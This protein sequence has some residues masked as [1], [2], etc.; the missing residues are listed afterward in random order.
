M[1]LPS[2]RM[3][4]PTGGLLCCAS[5]MAFVQ[6]TFR[7]LLYCWGNVLGVQPG[8]IEPRSLCVISGKGNQRPSKHTPPG[9]RAFWASSHHLTRIGQKPNLYGVCIREWPNWSRFQGQ[10]ICIWQFARPKRLRWPRPLPREAKHDRRC[11]V[12]L[13]AEAGSR[14]DVVSSTQCRQ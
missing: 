14:G 1:Q 12:R 3:L 2:S 13:E 8:W 4:L 7:N 5:V 6:K 11:R 9:L 10:R